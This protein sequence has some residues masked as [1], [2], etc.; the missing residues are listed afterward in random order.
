MSVLRRPPLR[1]RRPCVPASKRRPVRVLRAPSTSQSTLRAMKPCLPVVLLMLALAI[2][3]AADAT[4]YGAQVG[5]P[6]FLNQSRGVSTGDQ[7]VSSLKA[8]HAAGGRIGR[9]DSDWAGTEPRGPVDG[10]HRYHWGYDDLIAG[11]MAK[12]HLRWEPT[13][14]LA[15]KLGPGAP[16][17]RAPAEGREVRHA[18][19][20][21]QELHFRH[22]RDRVHAAL[23]RPRIVLGR[24]TGSCRTYRCTSS[25]CGTSPTTPTSGV[26][27]STST[28]TRRCMR[29][30]AVPCIASTPAR[31]WSPAG[32]PTTSSMPRLLKAFHHLRI[33]AVAVHLYS[34]TPKGTLALARFAIAQM[35]QFHR[36][37]TP[38]VVDEYLDLAS[39]HLGVHQTPK[40]EPLRVRGAGRALEAA[41]RADPA[42]RVD[43]PVVGPER[44]HVRE[45]RGADHP[46]R[47]LNRPRDGL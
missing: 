24:H 26:R 8:L 5:G 23:R 21:G 20:P 7:V 16:P 32:W 10:R 43:R 34:H 40:R 35:Q 19:A 9:A 37:S 3:A 27:G 18:A 25:K 15:P 22:V 47:P 28:I 14:E 17:E 46:A 30:S 11:E 13:L 29:R 4:T 2:P 42:V 44:R 45:G 1:T 41:H 6:H 39:R 36:G 33:D 12:A 38:L 31:A